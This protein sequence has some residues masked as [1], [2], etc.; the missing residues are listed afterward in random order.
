M[1][2]DLCISHSNSRILCYFIID[3][4]SS[5][6]TC[7]S[8]LWMWKELPVPLPSCKQKIECS[9]HSRSQPATHFTAPAD[10]RGAK[11]A[12]EPGS[13]VPIQ[14]ERAQ[15]PRSGVD[16][17]RGGCE[18]L[19]QPLP[20]VPR[21]QWGLSRL[22]PAPPPA[23]GAKPRRRLLTGRRSRDTAPPARPAASAA[24]NK[25]GG[26][27]AAITW[28]LRASRAGPAGAGGAGRRHVPPPAGGRTAEARTINGEGATGDA[29]TTAGEEERGGK[30]AQLRYPDQHPRPSPW[31][32]PAHCPPYPPSSPVPCGPKAPPVS[33]DAP[34][35]RHAHTVT[36]AACAAL[37]SLGGRRGLNAGG[38]GDGR[39]LHRSC[40]RE[41]R[42][43]QSAAPCPS[44]W[45]Y[46]PE[47][48][49]R[50]AWRRARA[51]GGLPLP[52]RC[53]PAP[54]RDAGGAAARGALGSVVPEREAGS[55]GACREVQSRSLRPA[56]GSPQHQ[57]GAREA[58][59]PRPGLCIRP[60]PLPGEQA[61]VSA[62]LTQMLGSLLQHEH[63]SRQSWHG[64]CPVTAQPSTETS[65][66]CYFKVKVLQLQP[67]YGTPC[68]NRAGKCGVHRV[69]ALVCFSWEF[70]QPN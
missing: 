45:L 19:C 11:A 42:R 2:G 8:C 22:P 68:R 37:P 10:L 3:S 21:R 58:L 36:G 6:L 70:S 18:G 26:G 12:P 41:G 44:G 28:W 64:R 46:T 29:G 9:F 48:T 30:G 50:P 27:R 17:S 23:L 4:S 57:L 5:H 35:P 65:R 14:P 34:R 1:K 25:D 55:R 66:L 32:N 16:S 53:A 69:T 13:E 47:D 59:A 20:A 67:C 31:G 54:P 38:S 49:P 63:T 39:G 15:A 40:W 43:R 60:Q 56:V 7:L 62:Q 51:A 24:P 33:P 61:R 52:A